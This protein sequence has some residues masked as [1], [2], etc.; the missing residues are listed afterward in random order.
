MFFTD[1]PQFFHNMTRQHFHQ[2]NKNGHI[3]M[4]P[5]IKLF[6]NWSK[7]VA[8]SVYL[9]KRRFELDNLSFVAFTT[10]KNSDIL[11]SF[12]EKIISK[13]SQ[14]LSQYS[15]KYILLHMQPS[16]PQSI[17]YLQEN[18]IK[19][20]NRLLRSFLYFSSCAVFCP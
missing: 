3:R 12:F 20:C 4:T 10:V 19:E 8:D 1:V 9:K 2:I 6:N 7:N 16:C 13:V 5:L 14:Y 18:H 11:L 15:S 17:F